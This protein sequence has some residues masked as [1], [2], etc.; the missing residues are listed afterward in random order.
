LEFAVLHIAAQGLLEHGLL[1]ESP[2][3]T[4]TQDFAA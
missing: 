3:S 4:R 2:G 1:R